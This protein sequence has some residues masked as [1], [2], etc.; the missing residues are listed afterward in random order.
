M[1]G[2]MVDEVGRDGKVSLVFNKSHT[3]AAP[4]KIATL[5]RF[6]KKNRDLFSSWVIFWANQ[7]A[8]LSDEKHVM[9][10]KI[11]LNNKIIEILRICE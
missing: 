7:W 8:L 9:R 3:P 11:R 1:L 2:D 10:R 4:R 6:T 5:T